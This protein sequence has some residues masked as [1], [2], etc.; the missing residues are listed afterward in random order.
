[1]YKYDWLR[2][3]NKHGLQRLQHLL[4]NGS[5][6]AGLDAA[7]LQDFTQQM[8][9]QASSPHSSSFTEDLQHRTVDLESLDYY[10]VDMFPPSTAARQPDLTTTAAAAATTNSGSSRNIKKK[11]AVDRDFLVIKPGRST[12]K[13]YPW[14]EEDFGLEAA[15]QV[16]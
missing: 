5:V 3:L 12:R 11:E 4:L 1:M 6:I 13:S 15:A 7:L 10:A 9:F 16:S 8:S 2:W 14:E